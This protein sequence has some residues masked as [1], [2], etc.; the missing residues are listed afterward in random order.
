MRLV[1][2]FVF[3]TEGCHYVEDLNFVSYF[4]R[5]SVSE[6][7]HELVRVAVER[8][9]D[10]RRVI[11]H[12]PWQ[13]IVLRLDS[14]KIA[15]VTD[16]EYPVGVAYE[17][18]SKLYH[19]PELLQTVLENCQDPRTVSAMYRIRQQLDE[20]IVIMHENIDKVLERGENITEL[21]EKSERLSASS[22]AFYK[23]ARKHNRCCTIS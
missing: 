18:M 15:M 7:M 19:Q 6:L 3:D 9:D 4:N 16:T 17:V 10:T 22:K 2:V 21:V 14:K 8:V 5:K 20:T 12:D 13:I 23:V 1:S 11:Q